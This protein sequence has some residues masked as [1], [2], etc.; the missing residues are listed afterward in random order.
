MKKILHLTGEHFATGIANSAYSQNTGFWTTAEGISLVRDPFSQSEDAG[1]LQTSPTPVEISGVSGR[2]MGS[3]KRVNASTQL[4]YL[5]TWDGST[6][7][8]LYSLNLTNDSANTVVS[9][10]FGDGAIGLDYIKLSTGDEYL[11]FARQAALYNYGPL[12]GTP[13]INSITALQST[14]WHHIHRFTDRYYFA[15][16]NYIGHVYD[17]GAGGFTVDVS[18][19]DVE[20]QYR[21]NCIS[22]DG[23]FVVAGMTDNTFTS[24]N[25]RGTTKIIFWDGYKSSW[26]QEWYIP[27]A[28]I[29]SIKN[30]PLGMIAV[31]SRGV[32][33]F[34]FTNPPRQLTPYLTT[35]DVPDYQYPTPYAVDTLGSAVAFGGYGHVSTFGKVRPEMPTAFMKPFAG[36]GAYPTTFLDTQSSTTRMLAG[37][38]EQKLYSFTYT[39]G[40]K[41]GI[42]G[43]SIF[44]DLKRWYQIGRITINFE[45][46]L[47]SGDDFTLKVQKNQSHTPETWGNPT[48]ATRGAIQSVDFY[49]SLTA[50]HLRL[51]FTFTGG[52]VKIKSVD[53]YA[54]PITTPAYA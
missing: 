22:D 18:A 28:A 25:I 47:A 5:M 27:D 26:D 52:N 8:S 43:E 30:T 6:T 10:G 9:S 48:Y 50:D 15:N 33:A 49:G 44:I 39:G 11:L 7:S 29:Y 42:T 35:A 4:L 45:T 36:L 20:S 54:D 31:T 13:G 53:V 32:W 46:P 1:I 24:P 34:S 19:L 23:R 40:G 14:P 12:G 38:T 37:T 41:T 51:I 3:A 2:I 16:A 21:V 17:D